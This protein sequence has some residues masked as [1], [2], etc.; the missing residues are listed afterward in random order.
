MSITVLLVGLCAAPSAL[1]DDEDD[2]PEPAPKHVSGH[3][4][5][6]KMYDAVANLSQPK[7]PPPRPPSKNAKDTGT[8]ST[9]KVT[10]INASRVD[11][12]Q[13]DA[14][15]F[16][17]LAVCDH[18]REIAAA[19]NDPELERQAEELSEKSWQVYTKQLA[20]SSAQATKEAAKAARKSTKDG[21]PAAF[22]FADKSG[23][24]HTPA[25]GDVR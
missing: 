15:Y 20:Q 21:K 19:K 9:G 7:A 16:R 23:N 12:A 6:N 3:G 5:F 2:A 14:A 17:R 18:L 25:N 8:S 24:S 13:A 11:R 10:I 22:A 1:A 4:I